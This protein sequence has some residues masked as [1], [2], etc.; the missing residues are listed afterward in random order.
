MMS[1]FPAWLIQ[2]LSAVYMAIFI[3]AAVVWLMG[4]DLDYSLWQAG[5]Q[6]MWVKLAVLLFGVSLLFHAWIGLRDVIVDYIHPLG[7]KV[8]KLSLLAL[9]LL[10]NGFWLFSILWGSPFLGQ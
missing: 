10:A 7:L 8:F 1:G 9:F 6:K 4:I 2:R 3:V 5:F